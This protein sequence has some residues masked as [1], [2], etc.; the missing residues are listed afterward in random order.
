MFE[1]DFFNINFE[2]SFYLKYIKIKYNMVYCIMYFKY[3]FNIFELFWMRQMVKI[4][5]R[6]IKDQISGDTEEV[7]NKQ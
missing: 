6:K 3:I 5:V 4:C 1:F 2:H 7:C